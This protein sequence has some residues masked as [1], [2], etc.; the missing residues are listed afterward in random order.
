[1]LPVERNANWSAISSGVIAGRNHRVTTNF[2]IIRDKI[3]VTEIGLKSERVPGLGILG[4]GVIT[5]VSH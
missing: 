4:T 3:G 5:A 2:S 1:M